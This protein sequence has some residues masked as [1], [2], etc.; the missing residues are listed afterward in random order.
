MRWLRK[1]QEL[2]TKI[3]RNPP[4]VNCWNTWRLRRAWGGHKPST[5]SAGPSPHIQLLGSSSSGATA[6]PPSGRAGAPGII[7]SAQLRSTLLI[8]RLFLTQSDAHQVGTSGDAPVQQLWTPAEHVLLPV[9]HPP[10]SPST[11]VTSSNFNVCL[12]LSD[13][14]IVRRVSASLH[15]LL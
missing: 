2:S 10:L 7:R 14:I 5:P 6:E 11:E 4:K 1:T 8:Q 15:S 13:S 3:R 9:Q 12:V